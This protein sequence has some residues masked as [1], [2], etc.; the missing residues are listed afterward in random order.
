M[1]D[2]IE[3]P[4]SARER[5]VIDFERE[6]FTV[7][8]AKDANLRRMLGISPSTYRRTLLAAIERR[9]AFLYDPLTV[10]RVRRQRDTRRRERLEGPR[11]DRS[12]P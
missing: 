8:G 9:A 3:R 5:A 7:P 4:L 2:A 1:T 6:W 11:V 12:R 10:S